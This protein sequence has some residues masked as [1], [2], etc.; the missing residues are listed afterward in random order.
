MRAL[1][2]HN[3]NAGT[4]PIPRSKIEAALHD[5]GI[6]TIYC[7]HG[8]DDLGEAMQARVD[9][10]VAAGGD[11]TVADVISG[12][13][14]ITRPVAILPLGGSNNIAHALGVD[15]PW[16]DLPG[17]WSLDAWTRLDRC[18]A[19]GPWGCKPFLEALGAGVLTD[20]FEDADE[21]P[22]SPAEKRANGRAAFEA[23][24]ARAEPF[25]CVVAAEDWQWEGE[26]LMVEAMNIGLVG[27]RLA[28]AHSAVPDD[29]LL[30]V[31][32][33]TP[34]Q[35]DD[36]LRWMKRPD[37]FPC[38]IPPRKAA[39][40]RITVHERPFRIDDR[41]PN[42]ETT[43]IADVRMCPTWVKVLTAKEQP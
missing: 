38:P 30:D 41:S 42:G 7:A 13:Q 40:V 16:H 34:E 35:R 36:L 27:S 39:S 9:L 22:A 37:D 29:G 25:H 14:D 18:E 21:E 33:I 20:S 23:A 28:L 3:A 24:V 1:L 4:D 8:D 32:I 19:D 17:R 31:V 26:C 15:G 10:I 12:L 2:V 43:G 6:E 5:A 11:G